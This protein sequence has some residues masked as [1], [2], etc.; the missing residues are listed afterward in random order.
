MRY[1]VNSFPEIA[2]KS[3]FYRTQIK[4]FEDNPLERVQLT[5]LDRLLGS[6]TE[7]LAKYRLVALKSI[8]DFPNEVYL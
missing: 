7:S 8:S 5:N 4:K 6:D 2:E 1:K 3:Y